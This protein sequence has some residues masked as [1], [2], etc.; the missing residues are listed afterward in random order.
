MYKFNDMK[1]YYYIVIVI[2]LC[3]IIIRLSMLNNIAYIKDKKH[4]DSIELLRDSLV[5]R[6]PIFQ[7]S[8]LQKIE[9]LDSINLDNKSNDSIVKVYL[10]QINNDSKSI[11]NIHKQIFLK[12]K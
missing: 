9:I 5:F 6:E 1:K 3:S 11:L 7:D 4:K 10:Q 2:F 12:N 8:L